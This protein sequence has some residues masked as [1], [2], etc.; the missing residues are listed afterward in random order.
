MNVNWWWW[1]SHWRIE[2]VLDGEEEETLLVKSLLDVCLVGVSNGRPRHIIR[3]HK[4][5][6]RKREKNRRCGCDRLRPRSH[7]SLSMIHGWSSFPWFGQTNDGSEMATTR[8]SSFHLWLLFLRFFVFAKCLCF[9]PSSSVDRNDSS[10]FNW[11]CNRNRL[12]FVFC[13]FTA[14]CGLCHVN[15]GQLN[16]WIYDA[17]AQRWRFTLVLSLHDPSQR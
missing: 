3:N 7:L 8:W 17:L 16:Q 6:F 12:Q 10:G 13:L 9:C 15:P 14:L 11:K 4:L 2:R 5:K 1:W